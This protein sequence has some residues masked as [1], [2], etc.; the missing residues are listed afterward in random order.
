MKHSR[1]WNIQ[2][3]KVTHLK[4][5]VFA[6]ASSATRNLFEITIA[7]D[8]LLLI[9]NML[10]HWEAWRAQLGGGEWRGRPGQQNEYFKYNNLLLRSTNFKLLSQTKGKF[11]KWLQFY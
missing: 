9:S 6:L 7:V 3:Y 5:H 2:I 8:Y 1:C 4:E 11:S 10:Q